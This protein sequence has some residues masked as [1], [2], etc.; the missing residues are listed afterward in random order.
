MA[1]Q[2][3]YETGQGYTTYCQMEEVCGICTQKHTVSDPFSGCVYSHHGLPYVKACTY[4]IDHG[5]SITPE[6]VKQKDLFRSVSELC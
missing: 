6:T 4:S 5:H 1:C 2:P 3:F